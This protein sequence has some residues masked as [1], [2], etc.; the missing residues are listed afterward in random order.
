VTRGDQG[1]KKLRC[2][3]DP[4]SER[5]GAGGG[6]QRSGSEGET[7]KEKRGMFTNRSDER[8]KRVN[9]LVA[10]L[11]FPYVCP[12]FLLKGERGCVQSNIKESQKLRVRWGGATG[13]K[14]R[15]WK[16]IG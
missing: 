10:R 1:E 2:G 11:T 9:R 12:A 4:E 5:R 6:R 15:S 16:R 8:K 14:A 13:N 7:E 3:H